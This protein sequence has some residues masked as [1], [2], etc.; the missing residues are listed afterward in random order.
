M[1]IEPHLGK[2][3][4]KGGFGTVYAI[5]NKPNL[6]VKKTNK[7]SNCR[8]WRNEY[9]NI[10]NIHKRLADNKL[11]NK[12]K[13]VQI[14]KPIQFI[15]NTNGECYMIM[16]RIYRPTEPINTQEIPSEPTINALFGMKKNN[17]YKKSERGEFY[18]LDKLNTI[19]NEKQMANV[20]NELGIIMDLF[21]FE[22]KIDAFDIELYVGLE[23]DTKTPCIYISDF[24]LSENIVDYTD[25]IIEDRICW[26]LE[27]M[28][29]FPTANSN[30]SQYN[31]FKNAYK[32]TANNDEIVNKIFSCY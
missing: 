28:P 19:F 24:D 11:F 16:N 17:Q 5:V 32:K 30:E 6:C 25:T 9:D 15:E 10:M 20:I 26:G 14:I 27:A 4:G 12:L 21:H 31:I 18:G 3:I 23:Y 8:L 2:E 22:A 7:K 29:Y 13:Y 1:D